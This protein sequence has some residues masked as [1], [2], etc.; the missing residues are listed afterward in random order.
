[1]LFVCAINVYIS[2]ILFTESPYTL[3]FIGNDTIIIWW[4]PCGFVV[5]WALGFAGFY[6]T[7]L[8]PHYATLCT[9]GRYPPRT[10][11]KRGTKPPAF[12]LIIFHRNTTDA[13]S[14]ANL[15]WMT[16]PDVSLCF[17]SAPDT[18]ILTRYKTLRLHSEKLWNS[19][20]VPSVS[21]S[22]HFHYNPVSWTC[23]GSLSCQWCCSGQSQC[24][25]FLILSG[26]K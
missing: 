2:W 16:S 21:R 15:W 7:S 5:H 17:H 1:M 10:A 20:R 6:D 22:G 8:N 19:I 12:M 25:A 4:F 23:V 14:G 18:G 11:W 24:V 9:E 26:V 13:S 3:M